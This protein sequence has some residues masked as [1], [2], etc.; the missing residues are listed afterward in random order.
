LCDDHGARAAGLLP[1]LSCEL[2]IA[3][4]QETRQFLMLR[5]LEARKEGTDCSLR[6]LVEAYEEAVPFGKADPESFKRE[7]EKAAA[8]SRQ[9]AKEISAGG[10]FQ[11]LQGDDSAESDERGEEILGDLKRFVDLPAVPLDR[12]RYLQDSQAWSPE[13]AAGLIG[14]IEQNPDKVLMRLEEELNDRQ[15]SHPSVSRRILFL[16]RNREAYPLR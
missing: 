12:A 6:D 11:F 7:L 3:A 13:L 8:K 9:N 1:A 10:F 15:A 2:K 16:W 4:E 14:L 5:M